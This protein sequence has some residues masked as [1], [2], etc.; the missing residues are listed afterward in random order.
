MRVLVVDDDPAEREVLR[1]LVEAWGHEVES[2]ADGEEAAELVATTRPQVMITDLHMPKLDGFEL[3]DRLR[4]EGTMPMTVV[5]TAFGSVETAIETVHRHGAFWFLEKPVNA[6]SLRVLIERAAEQARLAADNERLRTEL[7]QRGVLGELVGQSRP[8]QEVFAM[9][10]RVA[11]TD[12]SVLITGESGSGKELV[13]RAIHSN[14]HRAGAPFLAINCAAIPETLMESEIFGHE[15]GSFTGATE[16]KAGALELAEGGT[17]FL[18]EI[19][20]MPLA[21]QAKLLRVLEDFR[22]RRLGGKQELTANVRVLSATNRPPD[23]A[24]REGKLREDLYYRLNVFHIQ[25]PP[26]RDRRDDIPLIVDSML[27]RLNA[28]H[29]ARVTH[30]TPESIALLMAQPWEGNVRELRNIVERAVILAGEGPIEESHI[31]MKRRDQPPPVQAGG[32]SGLDIAV[33][34]TI[35][36]AEKVLIEATLRQ[37][38]NNKTRAAAVL[39]IST[40]TLH[41]KLR[42]Y[43]L[44]QSE[45]GEG[46]RPTA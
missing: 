4:G 39:G 27:G 38:G 17:L 6:E 12:A 35:D 10:R 44:E 21:L 31:M 41:A 37:A 14:S 45:N 5:L 33:G 19:G 9:I 46:E 24:L 29:D 26:L 40:K 11:P 42:Q 13:A 32:K 20:E 16:R 43:R 30:L 28:K 36:D 25:L 34:M 23:V 18:D 7:A 2:A 8:M 1:S 3:M 15:K 22:F